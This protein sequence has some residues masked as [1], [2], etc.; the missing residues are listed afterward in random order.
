MHGRATWSPLDFCVVLLG[1]TDVLVK[2]GIWYG[3]TT[4]AWYIERSPKIILPDSGDSVRMLVEDHFY[5]CILDNLGVSLRPLRDT[6]RCINPTIL[7]P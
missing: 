7:F 5:A 3:F 4:S 2:Y 1:E 6:P